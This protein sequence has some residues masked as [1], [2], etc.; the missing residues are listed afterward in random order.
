VPKLKADLTGDSCS[1][2]A[3]I[4]FAVERLTQTAFYE[5]QAESTSFRSPDTMAIT[6]NPCEA[7]THVCGHWIVSV[8]INWLRNLLLCPPRRPLIFVLQ[9]RADELSL[10]EWQRNFRH[11][12][13]VLLVTLL[14][15]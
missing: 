12:S 7:Q 10:A 9:A 6:L 13:C 8:P 4:S 14:S 5:V 11:G 2:K 1:S 3:R 15:G